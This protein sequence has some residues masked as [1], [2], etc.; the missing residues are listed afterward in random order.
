MSVYSF[1]EY[2][3]L[4]NYPLFSNP[5]YKNN[6]EGVAKLKLIL[7]NCDVEYSI[8]MMSTIILSHI[9]VDLI[10]KL[11]NGIFIVDGWDI[12]ANNNGDKYTIYTGS[13]SRKDEDL[14]TLLKHIDHKQPAYMQLK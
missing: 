11:D 13:I 3:K 5:N 7:D 8:I 14:I 6:K 1:L 12:I 4:Q 2:C 9:T 10:Y